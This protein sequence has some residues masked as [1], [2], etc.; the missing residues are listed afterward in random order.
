MRFERISSTP[1]RRIMY[2]YIL[3][4]VEEQ[5]ID[6]AESSWIEEL[7]ANKAHYTPRLRRL[8]LLTYHDQ[9][10]KIT[11]IDPD[12]LLRL[13]KAAAEVG[14]VLEVLAVQ[15]TETWSPEKGEESATSTNAC[16]YIYPRAFMY[17]CASN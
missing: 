9:H 14:I 17:T 8:S 16:R 15:N 2:S 13:T 11:F 12:F 7:L 10:P 4:Q 5:D 6:T 1:D 3:D